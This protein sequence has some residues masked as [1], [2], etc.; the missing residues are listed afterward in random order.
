MVDSS[1]FGVE[2][3]LGAS[4]L[5]SSAGLDVA[6]FVYFKIC[7]WGVGT[8][9][10]ER[11]AVRK[12]KASVQTRRCLSECVFRVWAST[13]ISVDDW[14]DIELRPYIPG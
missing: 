3:A 6:R 12:G 9:R 13:T 5:D 4:A 2:G 11:D 1:N 10:R 7:R 8:A 14:G